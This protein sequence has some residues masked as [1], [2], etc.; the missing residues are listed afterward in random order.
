MVDRRHGKRPLPSETSEKK[1]KGRDESADMTAMVTALTQVM[2]TDQQLITFPQS[3]QSTVK[4]E[5]AVQ[6]IQ[7]GNPE[8]SYLTGQGD[9]SS[10]AAAVG[11]EQNPTTS[12]AI[13][14]PWSQ[15]SYPDLF[16]Y[17]QLLSSSNDADISYYTSNLFNQDQLPVSPQF[18]SM[19]ASSTFTSQHHLHPHQ[20]QTRFSNYD[21]SS[22]GYDYLN[23]QYGKDFDPS[24]RSE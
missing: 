2:A 12:P 14:S 21:Q 7:P 15:D 24:N 10:T 5:A 22:S 3:S 6:D 8:I 19:S 11:P 4:Q 1:N 23:H 9:S 17:A 20:D 13:P 18:P 16:Q